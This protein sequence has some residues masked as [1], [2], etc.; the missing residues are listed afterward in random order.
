MARKR[1][2]KQEETPEIIKTREKRKWQIAFRRYVVEKQPCL[3]YA[4][5]FGLDIAG[6][7][8][9]FAVQFREGVGWEDFGALWQFEHILPVA[10]FDFSNENELRACWNFTNIRV[11]YTDMEKETGGRLNLLAARN[12]FQ[13]LYEQT[14]YAPC[15]WLMEKTVQ[16]E[17][18]ETISSTTQAGFINTNK[19]FLE[20]VKDFSAYE[21][22]LLN[23]GKTIGEIQKE[24]SFLK[25]LEK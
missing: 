7:R 15:K 17:Q 20:R 21:F 25:N 2:T 12:F 1:Y 3:S 19:E 18:A 6:I 4:P 14:G 9:W 22:E 23:N 11:D 10:C 16:I 24:I 8:E 13:S 5:Y